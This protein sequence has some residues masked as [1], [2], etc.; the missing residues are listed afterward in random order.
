MAP[1]RFGAGWDRLQRPVWLYD[2]QTGQKPYANPAA[3]SLWGAESLS[4]L[5]DRDFSAQSPAMKTRIQRLVEQTAQG[6]TVRERWAFFP[7]GQPVTAQ[8]VVSRFVD[9]DGQALLLFEATLEDVPAEERRAAEALRHAST[10]ISLFDIDGTRLFSNPA[11]FG[12]YGEMEGDFTG[13]FAAQAEGQAGRRR[14]GRGF[15]AAR[16]DHPRRSAPAPHGRPARARLGH[17][18]HLHSAGR[19]GCDA[20]GGG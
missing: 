16:G 15:R 11:A 1:H 8:A 4:A 3:L 7:H 18:P 14:R 5:A 9:D 20:S 2:P 6:Q 17:R 10:L 12:A 19:T 13:R